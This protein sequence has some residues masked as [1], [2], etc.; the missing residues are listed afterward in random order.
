MGTFPAAR[1][2]SE[3]TEPSNTEDEYELQKLLVDTLDQVERNYVHDISRRELVEAAIRGILQELDPYSGYIDREEISQFRTTVDSQFGGIG[4]RISMDRRQLKVLS[5]LVGTPAYRAGV[6][7]GD[8]IVKINEESTKGF[9]IDDAV[10]RLKGEPDTK[11]T[12]TVI[13]PGKSEEVEIPIVREVVQIETVLGDHRRSDDSWDFVLDQQ[14]QIGYIRLTAFSRN[15]ARDLRRGLAS[16]KKAGIRGLILDLRFNP[17]GLLT[18]AIEVSDLFVSNGRIVSTEGRNMQPREWDAKARGTFD[19]F[20]MVVLVNRFSASASEIVSACLQDHHRAVVM[21]ERT[22]GKGSVQNVI[23][24]EG[25]QSALKLTTAGYHRP[26]GKNINRAPD[27]TEED[28]WGVIPDEGYQLRLTDRQMVALVEDRRQRDVVQSHQA[29]QTRQAEQSARPD[30]DK[31]VAARTEKPPA[32]DAQA[33]P[34]SLPPKAAGGQA[35]D[36]TQ[37]TDSTPNAEAAPK[38]GETPEA[39][40]VPKEDPPADPPADP[41]KDATPEPPPAAPASGGGAE[42]EPEASKAS[43]PV[44][45]QLRMAIDYLIAELA[46]AK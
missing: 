14:N 13:H 35:T 25:G 24:M 23:E 36:S 34:A 37:K 33:S 42:V 41:P 1:A 17:G 6:L 12:L 39:D 44:D 11:V 15:T 21:G 20:K 27:A 18:S 9:T 16:L 29:E 3:T 2:W 31:P 5:P 4:I 40:T 43:E 8:R 38:T 46:R 7:A 26:S 10:K 28:E 30:Q 19:D 22:W 45:A 32:D